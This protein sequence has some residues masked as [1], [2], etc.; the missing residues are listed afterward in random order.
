MQYIWGTNPTKSAT[1]KNGELTK[2]W[3]KE[4]FGCLGWFLCLFFQ[5]KGSLLLLLLMLQALLNSTEY[6][7]LNMEF[8]LSL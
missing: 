8:S 4:N 1:V 3:F 2:E 6:L 5:G 7:Q